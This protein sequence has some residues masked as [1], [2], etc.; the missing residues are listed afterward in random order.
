MGLRLM[1]LTQFAVGI[2]TG[3]VEVAQAHRFQSVSHL[4][5][6]QHLLDH[7]LAA[8]V[9][10]DGI[11]GMILVDG[12]PQR[13]AENRRRGRKDEVV[14]PMRDH[15]IQQILGLEHVVEVVLGRLAHRFADLDMGGEMQHAVEARGPEQLI[16]Q[17]PFAQIPQYEASALDRVTVAGGQ[18]VQHRHLEPPLAE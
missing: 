3:G 15:R 16:Q 13:F 9:G 7:P 8:S 12:C 6:R 18:I 5:I 10:V 4:V 11:L 14:D 2:G 17:V 1:A